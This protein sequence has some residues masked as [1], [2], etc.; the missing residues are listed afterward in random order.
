VTGWR[1]GLLGTAGILLTTASAAVVVL[2][3]TARSLGPVSA[4]ADLLSGV[5]A[6]VLL[7]GAT[8]V[9]AI[10]V[11]AIARSPA[12]GPRAPP[13]VA[14]RRFDRARVRPPEAVTADRRQ[15]TATSLDA[16][17]DTAVEA[18][19][20]PLATLRETLSRTAA[21]VYADRAGVEPGRAREAVASGTWTGDSTA[22]AFL[23]G[24]RGPTPDLRARLRLWLSPEAERRRRID[25]TLAAVRRLAEDRP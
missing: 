10:Y 4:L 21:E 3:G 19:G 9:A 14:E 20:E 22:A 24:D 12:G 2:P 7:T 25:R 17:V 1:D 23:A 16:D 11:A 15:V 8:A 18:G 6:T 13:S 5:G